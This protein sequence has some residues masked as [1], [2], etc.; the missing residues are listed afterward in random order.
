MTPELEAAYL[1]GLASALSVGYAGTGGRWYCYQCSESSYSYTGKIMCCS[2]QDVDLYYQKG[3]Q[4]MDA[5]IMDG[6][7]LNAGA[8]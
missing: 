6:A 2:M 5:A 1:E 4:E 8:L 3:V 7:S